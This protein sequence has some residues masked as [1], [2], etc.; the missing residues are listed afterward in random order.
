MSVFLA[1]SCEIP[2]TEFLIEPLLLPQGSLIQ[3]RVS[4]INSI[5]QSVPSLTNSAGSLVEQVP[6]KPPTAPT[7]NYSST[8][9]VIVVDFLEL[10][11]TANGGS[12]VLAYE[13]WWD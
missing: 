6:H 1:L 7:K 11:G 5:G 13:L 10:Q 12:E 2:L 9:N 8:Q 4:A 3:A